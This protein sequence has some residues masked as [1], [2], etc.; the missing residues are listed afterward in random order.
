QILHVA[1]MFPVIRFDAAM[2]L[3]KMHIQRLWFPLPGHAPGVPSR[4][5]WSMSMADFEAAMPQEFWREVVDRVAQEVP[6]TLLLAEAF[7]MLEGYFVRTLGMHRVYNSAFMHMLKK[8]DNAGY[9]VLIKKTLEFD[10]EILKRYVN[11]M[12]NPDEDTAIAQFGRGD[13]YVGVCMMMVTMPG[14][15][16]FGHGQV[17]G[18]TEKYGMEYAKAYYDEHPDG[19][20]VAR[21]YR[22]IFP[23]TQKRSLFAEVANFQL[24]DLYA[25]DGQVNEHVFVY[26]NRLGEQRSLFIYNNRYDASEGWIRLSAARLDNGSFR[27]TLLADALALPQEHDSYAIFRDHQSGLEFIRSCAAISDN[28]LY[29]ALGGYQ[30]NLFL[31]FRL[32]RPSKLKP[33]DRVC[34]ELDGRGVSSV[35]LETLSM[36]LRPIHL[37]VATA[38]ERIMREPADTAEPDRQAEQFGAECAELLESFSVRFGEIMETALTLPTGITEQAAESYYTALRFETTLGDVAGSNRIKA[39][40]GIVEKEEN[41][42]R[43][44]A[45]TL[46]TLDAIQ[47]MLQQ[48]GLLEEQIIDQLMLGET[49]KTLMSGKTAWPFHGEQAVDLFSCLLSRRTHAE[50]DETP[51]DRL[52]QSIRTLHE[53]GD[54]HFSSFLQVQHLHDKEWFRERQLTILAAWLMAQALIDSDKPSQ[55]LWLEAIE[56]LETAAFLSGYELT[57][58]LQPP[59]CAEQ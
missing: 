33:Y 12:N 56:T 6:D 39:A 20:L 59:T 43:P 3:A 51:D 13:K 37:L 47:Q 48:N 19:E 23:V 22:E 9:R 5:G 17:E 38:L 52:M 29:I 54:L 18:L 45:K 44:L 4:G 40:L 42:F 25:P 50:S 2:V 28:G 7:W 41:A 26:S 55:R 24:F 46:I 58:L 36:S 21:H 31:D 35:E 27:Q 10:A 53:S 16:M 14:L 11:F 49:V 32:V 30:Y 1:R 34:H 57:T 8:E 15:P